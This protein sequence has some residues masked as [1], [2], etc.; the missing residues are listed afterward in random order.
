MAGHVPELI[1]FLIKNGC[2]A[3][4]VSISRLAEIESSLIE[5]KS[6]GLVNAD[7]YPELTRYFN[8]DFKAALPGAT[9]IIIAASPQPPTRVLFGNRAVIIPPT[10]IYS[11]IWKKQ[12]KL[13]TDFLKPHG[14]QVARARLPF[15]TLAMRSGLGRYG[16]NN[17]CYIPGMGSFHRLG[18]FYSDM[19]C[20]EENWGAPRA[21][22]LCQTCT[23]CMDNCPTRC[24]PA[25]RF[26]VHADR[27]L[28]HFNESGNPLP[29]WLN[30]EWHNALLG[31]MICQEVCPLN[32]E[33]L[34][35]TQD[36]IKNF[37]RAETEEILAGTP[38][39]NLKAETLVKLES[40]C[41][42][43]SDVY[44]LLKRNLALLIRK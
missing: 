3:Q 32:K 15:K 36:A 14:Y 40:L 41:L 2:K 21:M 26:L 20:E 5:L 12:L 6:L 39:E 44:P 7:F 19:P 23:S 31:C 30:P 38:L 29:V 1:E 10:Y 27:C 35:K 34:R 25:D 42:A 33:F 24:I 4:V 16:R 9:S 8:F 28:T 37:T 22:K 13:V 43:D 18:A 11:D 17:I